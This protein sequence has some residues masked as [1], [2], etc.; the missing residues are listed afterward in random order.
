VIIDIEDEDTEKRS[1][2]VTWRSR[3][4]IEE[5]IQAVEISLNQEEHHG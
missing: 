5:E 3:Y 2:Y 4:P 1:V